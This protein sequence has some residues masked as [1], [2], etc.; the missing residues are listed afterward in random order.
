M[1]YPTLTYPTTSSPFLLV[2]AQTDSFTD[3]DWRSVSVECE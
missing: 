2:V 1:T 3:F